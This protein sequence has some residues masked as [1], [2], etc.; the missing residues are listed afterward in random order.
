MIVYRVEHRKTGDGP[1]FKKSYIYAELQ[2]LLND[3]HND[4]ELYPAFQYDGITEAE[5]FKKKS[6]RSGFS[7]KLKAASWFKGFGIKLSDNNFVIAVYEV[8]EQDVIHGN[9][10]KQ[11][12]FNIE[13]AELLRAE[14]I[15]FE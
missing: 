2:D 4:H 1:Y 10:G 12:A 8:D 3:E 5:T 14:P 15:D 7:D 6:H 13:K 9:S 11:L